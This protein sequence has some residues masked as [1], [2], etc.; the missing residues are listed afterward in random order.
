MRHFFV[1]EDGRDINDYTFKVNGSIVDPVR[2]G[3]YYYIEITGIS[4]SALDTAYTVTVGGFTLDN[5]SALTYAKLVLES[6]STNESLK[7]VT[8]ALYLYNDAANALFS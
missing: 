5:Y 1:L 8:R 3:D 6:P 7:N 4:A 2:S